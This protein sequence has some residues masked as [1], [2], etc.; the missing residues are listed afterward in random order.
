MIF[1]A[2]F[3]LLL[4]LAVILLIMFDV[5]DHTIAALVGGAI[6]IFYFAIIWPVWGP[7]FHPELPAQFGLEV[8][9][10]FFTEWVD[11][12]TIIVIISMMS[13]TEIAKD[14]GLF[15]YVAVK[16]IRFSKGNP[17]R[18]LIILCLLSFAMCMVL[19]QITT[20]LI[21]GSLAIVSS[22]ALETNSTPYLISIAI[23]SN[24]GGI[25]TSIASVPSMLIAGASQVGFLWFI[26]NLM[27]LGLLLLGVTVFLVIR[28]FRREFS[29]PSVD[30]VEELMALDAWEM[31]P[32]RSVFY[33]TAIL[34]GFI[35]VGFVVLGSI[36]L[37]FLVALGGAI[38]FILLSGNPP[39]QVLREIDW[40]AL[41]FF[42]GLFLL[43]GL[44]E[45]FFILET[46]GLAIQGQT[47]GNPLLATIM[48][49]W[50]T[51]VTSGVVDNIP[52]ALTLIPVVEILGTGAVPLPKGPLWA[53]LTAGAVLGGCLTPIASAANV[54]AVKLAEREE[55]PIPYGKFLLVGVI[56]TS[57]YLVVSTLYLLFRLLIFPIP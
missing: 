37:S 36:G 21:V 17:Q 30:R 27:P 51:G 10:H 26:I 44:M 54:L 55:R 50:V 19:T 31:V 18:L 47:M 34:L 52:V 40:S 15:Q 5:V 56:L 45:E 29:V 13:I 57:I 9:G 4:F 28:I 24:V 41:F 32:D 25:T 2:I 43:V 33:R 14:S 22:D 39:S 7:V 1:P 20:I 38:A 49:L 35:I 53:A 46:I 6:A 3:V 12:G 42:L 11:L 16:A 23:V 8:F 48:M